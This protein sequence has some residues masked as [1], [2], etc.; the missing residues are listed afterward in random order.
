[1]PAKHKYLQDY[2]TVHM[3]VRYLIGITPPSVPSRNTLRYVSIQP[4]TIM[5]FKLGLDIFMYLQQ[6]NVKYKTTLLCSYLK[7]MLLNVVS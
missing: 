5:L 2:L 3:Y 1:M 7:Q 4:I 6:N